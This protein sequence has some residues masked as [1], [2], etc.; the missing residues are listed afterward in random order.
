MFSTLFFIFFPSIGLDEGNTLLEV[1]GQ[2]LKLLQLIVVHSAEGSLVHGEA[3]HGKTEGLASTEGNLGV[4]GLD[5][6]GSLKVK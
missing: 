2:E 1:L 6:F 3:L 5:S 4:F